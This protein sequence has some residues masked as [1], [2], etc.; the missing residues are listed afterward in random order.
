M[1]GKNAAII[2]PDAPLETAINDCVRS[3]LTT[4][5]QRCNALSRI[6]IHEDSI[7][8]FTNELAN[9]V[10][11]WTVGHYQDERTKMGPLVSEEALS[12]FLQ[13][14]DKAKREGARSVLIGRRIH[15]R[16]SGYYITPA[17]HRL[18][19]SEPRNGQMGYR[20][21]EIFG[22]DI[23][24]YTYKTIEEAIRIHNDCRYGLVASVYTKKK[25]EFE[26]MYRHLE[27]GNLHWNRPTIVSSAHLPFGGIKA[28]GNDFPAGLFSP[29]F[30]TY[31][32]AVQT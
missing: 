21:D 9:A 14:Q 24:V 23:A 28:S 7:T 8:Q 32:V 12:R 10:L 11:A 17:M 15:L 20:Y 13:Y 27:V 6:I 1:G 5:G 30:C 29:L 4:T 25:A 18:E 31:P 3:A 2:T 22:P 16:K 26:T 19:W